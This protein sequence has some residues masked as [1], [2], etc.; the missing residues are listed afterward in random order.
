MELSSCPRGAL[1]SAPSVAGPSR[2]VVAPAPPVCFLPASSR[3]CFSS[4]HSAL[5]ASPSFAAPARSLSDRS[6]RARMTRAALTSASFS[7]AQPVHRKR[8]AFRLRVDA[9][10]LA[11]CVARV[12]GGELQGPS[13]PGFDRSGSC[14]LGH[15]P[16]ASA[17]A[18]VEPL[19]LLDIRDATRFRALGHRLDL[20]RFEA[21]VWYV[22]TAR[23]QLLQQ[24]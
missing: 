18:P 8:L 10:A 20:Q 1:P 17:D 21:G 13:A 4:S 2:G 3:A 24:P 5:C 12:H 22:H 15:A 19:P 16:A 23:V 14:V 6:V 9:S 11:A 7:C